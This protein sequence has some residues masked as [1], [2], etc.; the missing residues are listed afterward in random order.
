MISST[1]QKPELHNWWRNNNVYKKSALFWERLI[2][3]LA[4]LWALIL[5]GLLVFGGRSY[6]VPYPARHLCSSLSPGMKV[7]DAK[8]KITSFGRPDWLERR[9]EQ[10]IIASHDSGCLVDIDPS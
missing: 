7:D 10:L 5:D 6:A 9:N 4:L 8:A 2:V 1:L 3:L